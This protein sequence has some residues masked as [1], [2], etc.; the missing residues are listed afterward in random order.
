MHIGVEDSPEGERVV[1]HVGVEGG[2]LV[3]VTEGID[4]PSN[5]WTNAELVVNVLVTERHLVDDVLVLSRGLVGHDPASEVEL[6]LRIKTTNK[7][8]SALL[9]H[10]LGI[11]PRALILFVPPSLEEGLLDESKDGKDRL[12][13]T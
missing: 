12:R 11:R 3:A 9:D 6:Q 8:Y 13:N 7:S 4:V 1:S 2:H 5:S 10:L